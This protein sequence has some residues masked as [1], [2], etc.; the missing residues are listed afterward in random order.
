LL[1]GLEAML[2]EVRQQWWLL[3]LVAVAVGALVLL[4]KKR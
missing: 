4:R 3:I 1:R 2:H